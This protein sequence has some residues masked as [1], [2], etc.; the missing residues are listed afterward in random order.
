M[1]PIKALILAAGKSTRISLIAKNLPK[2]LLKI[3]R[4]PVLVH[5]LELL[6]KN[7]IKTVWINLHYQGTLIRKEIGNGK[8]FGVTVHYSREKTILGTAGAVKKL[9]KEF[10]REPFL[11]LYGD[12]LTDCDLTALLKTHEKSKAIATIAVFNQKENLNSGIAGGRVKINKNGFIK[13]FIEGNIRQPQLSNYVNAGIYALEPE[14]LNY[15]PTGFSDFGK[16]IFPK[17]LTQNYKIKTYKL[18]GY[19]L[20]VDTPDSYSQTLKLFHN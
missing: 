6:A 13:N 1:S 15:I 4:K 17:L 14:I 12:N 10:D 8:K 18:K 7:N 9:K 11:V 5:N 2:P 3:Q 16:D 20:A 19:C